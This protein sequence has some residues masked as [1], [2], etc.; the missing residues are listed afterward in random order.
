MESVQYRIRESSDATEPRIDVNIHEV[1]VVLPEGSDIDPESLLIENSR[2]VLKKK[3]K[4]DQYREDAPERVFEPGETFPYLGEE[5]ELVIESRP[6][7][8]INDGAIR[9]R[10]SAVSQSSIKQVLENFYRSRAREYLTDRVEQYAEEMELEYDSLQLRN[11]RTRWGSCSS[12]GILSFN[13][14]LIMAP[15]AVIDYVV[16]HELAH[17][18]EPNHTE[19]FW[20]LVAEHDSDYRWH[21]E[22]LEEHSV[23]LIFSEEDL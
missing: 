22:W 13:W 7:N 1:T 2:W 16:V 20:K 14:R 17:L 19:A 10:Q 21:A 12:N 9:L 3:R 11:Q 4:Y 6:K 18:R 23:E 5:H 15:P 8:T